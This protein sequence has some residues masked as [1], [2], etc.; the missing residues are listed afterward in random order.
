VK[1][2]ENMKKLWQ[3]VCFGRSQS[4]LYRSNNFFHL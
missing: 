1:T 4:Y 3:R 2:I